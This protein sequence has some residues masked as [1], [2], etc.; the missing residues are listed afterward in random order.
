MLV[1]GDIKK[2][3]LVLQKGSVCRIIG[4]SSAD[5]D[6]MEIDFFNF[7]DGSVFSESVDPDR[8]FEEPELETR[9]MKFKNKFDNSIIFSNDSG[10]ELLDVP[11]S[12][13]GENVRLLREDASVTA[14]YFENMIVSLELPKIV[15]Q[16]IEST[17][18][19]EK[20]SSNTD[21]VKEARLANGK[22][23]IVPAFIKNGDMVKIHLDT[24]E[25]ICRE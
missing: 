18:D 20:D 25:Y 7:D 19:I 12:V 13:L 1:A 10:T 3:N 15:V 14:K 5:T 17:V 8:K 4:A 9:E 11:F 24:G 22:T 16:E 21:Y 2:G 6:K 23:I